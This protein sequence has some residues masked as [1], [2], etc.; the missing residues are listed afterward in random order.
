M[1][2]RAAVDGLS[3]WAM[4]KRRFN[5]LFR[6]DRIDVHFAT[7]D[8]LPLDARGAVS[9]EAGGPG[10][11]SNRYSMK[12]QNE[13]D[14][15]LPV[16]ELSAKTQEL[17][18]S[19]IHNSLLFQTFEDEHKCTVATMMYQEAVK[20]G[21]TLIVEGSEGNKFYVI[22]EGDFDVYQVQDGKQVRVD[23]H[24]TGSSFGELALMYDAPRNA[25]VVAVVDSKVRVLER[26]WFNRI[27]KELGMARLQ[28][29]SSWLKKV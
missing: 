10:G 13:F 19:A 27:A 24:K 20:A 22:E 11:V 3:L 28:Q 26:V 23:N 9:A 14:G 7:R 21:D 29:Y 8:E 2:V 5:A 4:E 1:S 18:L 15:P 12:E 25:T 17:V 6:E 16:Q